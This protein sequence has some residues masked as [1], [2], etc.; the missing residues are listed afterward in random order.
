MLFLFGIFNFF[1][2]GTK[3][4]AHCANA[5]I[6]TFP[7]SADFYPKKN[8]FF[9]IRQTRQVAHIRQMPFPPHCLISTGNGEEVSFGDETHGINIS[10]KS[11]VLW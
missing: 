8:S 4:F 5:A 11:N 3:R 1:D 6:S 2:I 10:V 7:E 9:H